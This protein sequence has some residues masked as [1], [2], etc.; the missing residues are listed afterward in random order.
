MKTYL[1]ASEV[2]AIVGLHRFMSQF[3]LWAKIH[4]L[5]PPKEGNDQTRRGHIIE[6]ALRD[7]YAGFLGLPVTAGPP[8]ESQPWTRKSAPWQSARPDAFYVTAAGQVRLVE[9]KTTNSWEHWGE[10][11]SA[12]I[13]PDYAVQ[14]LWQ[15]WVC[16]DHLPD[17]TGTDVLT[18]NRFNDEIRLFLIDQ[19]EQSRATAARLSAR[20]TRWWEKHAIGKAP[21]EADGSEA[22]RDALRALYGHADNGEELSP[23][24]ERI[25]LVEAYRRASSAFSAAEADKETTRNQLIAAIGE[26]SGIRNLCTYRASK[27]KQSFNLDKF[28]KEH[29]EIAANYTTVGEPTRTLKL[30]KE[31]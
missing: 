23:T 10:D 13:P 5:I 16:G 26:A 28:R 8:Y 12:D 19:T 6:P 18:F 24:E 31:R 2:A 1:G 14:V 17:L 20:V 9:I 4:E 25:R 11:K 21:P 15:Q 30:T 7:W 22:T 3:E 27:P 29:P